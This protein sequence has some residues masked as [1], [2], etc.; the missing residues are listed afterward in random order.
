MSRLWSADE[1]RDRK[2]ELQP[3][4]TSVIVDDRD[5]LMDSSMRSRLMEIGVRERIDFKFLS[6]RL[7]GD[8]Q[9]MLAKDKKRREDDERALATDML[10]AELSKVEVKE[11]KIPHLER[12]GLLRPKEYR[13]KTKR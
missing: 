8:F 1:L 9:S 5:G 10:I 12:G 4:R 7:P 6:E 3:F 13:Y 11:P 2:N